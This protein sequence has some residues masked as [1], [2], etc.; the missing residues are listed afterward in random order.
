LP[1][2]VLLDI[3]T[4]SDGVPLFIEELTKTV[5]ES[6]LLSECDGRFEL[7]GPQVGLAAP[8]TLRDSLLARLNRLG[9]ARKVAQTAAAIG[10]EFSHEL[11]AAAT[12][13][14]DGALADALNQLCTAELVSRRATD[15]AATYAFK[16]ALVR[17]MAYDS[18]LREERQ[19]LHARIAAAI[20]A[21]LPCL[22]GEALGELA[23][24]LTEAG[25]TAAAIVAWE[26]ASARST[27]RFAN[28]RPWGRSRRP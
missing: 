7:A 23:H 17:G 2:A 1:H 12:G 15:P 10:R 14:D 8:A 5:L 16:H 26:R 3:L 6:G 20:E 9:P 24:H 21:R 25:A 13:L 28:E 27:T 11:L 22:G 4:K 19:S 18:L